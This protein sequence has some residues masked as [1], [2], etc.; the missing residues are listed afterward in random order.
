M[1]MSWWDQQGQIHRRGSTENPSARDIGGSTLE[2][3]LHIRMPLPTQ[4]TGPWWLDDTWRVTV[5]FLEHWVSMNLFG[6]VTCTPTHKS[7]VSTCL[8]RDTWLPRMKL[9]T[10]V[11]LPWQLCDICSDLSQH[12]SHPMSLFPVKV[13]DR[14]NQ[15]FIISGESG[16]GKTETAKIALWYALV[17]FVCLWQC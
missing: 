12:T 5:E 8:S 2:L 10:S 4:P 6:H 3:C 16:A 17:L 11:W 9:T 1:S 14:K 13:R 15:G 7:M